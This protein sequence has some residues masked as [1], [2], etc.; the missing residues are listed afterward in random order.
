MTVEELKNLLQKM[1]DD[2]KGDYQVRL[3]E[4]EYHK[5]DEEDF[6]IDDK[7]ETF[8]IQSTIETDSQ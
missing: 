5:T 8:W 7:C 4:N 3:A 1:V 6:G 2:G